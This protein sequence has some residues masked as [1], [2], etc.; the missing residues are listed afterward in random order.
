MFIRN[1][2]KEEAP[3][4]EAVELQYKRYR[5][6]PC[7]GQQIHRGLK[8]AGLRWLKLQTGGDE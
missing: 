6:I 7:N 1:T 2:R 4:E 8:G 5:S 3:W